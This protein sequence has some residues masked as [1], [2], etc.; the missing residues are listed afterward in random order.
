MFRLWFLFSFLIL[1]HRAVLDYHNFI[2]ENFLHFFFIFL[3]KLFLEIVNVEEIFPGNSSSIFKLFASFFSFSNPKRLSTSHDCVCYLPSITFLTHCSFTRLMMTFN[4]LKLANS[5]FN[6]FHE[7]LKYQT[8]VVM[9]SISRSIP[10]CKENGMELRIPLLLVLSS[11]KLPLNSLPLRSKKE[12]KILSDLLTTEENSFPLSSSDRG[13]HSRLL[14]VKHKTR[15]YMINFIY[16][17]K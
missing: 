12:W 15:M 13:L 3:C 4:S 17:M 2:A 1:K 9:A 7:F 10:S 11:Y 5:I 6:L 16:N 8:F 14:F